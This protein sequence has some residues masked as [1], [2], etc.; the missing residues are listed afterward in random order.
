MYLM[1]RAGVRTV[2]VNF[3][4]LV[5]AAAVTLA[6]V[7]TGALAAEDAGDG[8]L[9][10]FQDVLANPQDNA[11]SFRYARQQVAEGNLTGAAASLERMLINNPDLHEVRLFHAVLLYRLDNYLEAEVELRRIPLAS[12][13]EK[14]RSE[15]ERYLGLIGK[16]KQTTRYFGIL[17][18]GFEYD[19][20]V[21]SISDTGDVLFLGLTLTIPDGPDDFG[22]LGRATVGFEHELQTE[23]EMHI[24]GDVTVFANEHIEAKSQSHQL[25]MGRVG[26]VF[27]TGAMDITPVAEGGVLRLS[28]EFFYS[29][30]GI[31]LGA[32]RRVAS[33]LSV[34]AGLRW[35]YEEFDAIIESPGADG[36]TGHRYEVGVGTTYRHAPSQILDVSFNF[37][38][39]DGK[40]DFEDYY[41]FRLNASLTVGLFEGHFA[42]LTITAGRRDYDGPEAF[43]SPGL[44]RTDQYGRA[45]LT[46]GLPL[47]YLIGAL[48]GGAPD[49]LAGIN[50][51]P[52]VE[53]Y[54]QSSNLPNFDYDNIKVSL[55]L[56]K[57]FDF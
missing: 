2:L 57:K 6:T 47:S 19:E 28:E 39:K 37:I 12:L 42:Q 32:T 51:L 40:V 43:V 27:R 50:V 35:R 3:K 29:F 54:K 1:G 38:G 10:S 15:V 46:Y 14:L 52:A 24:F 33:K 21:N 11:L 9:V 20:N 5:M 8:G 44:A 48:G 31:S 34:N 53:Y 22:F 17:G 41:G 36:R 26:T 16:R 45:R 49:Y 56:S 13:T 4:I 30:G 23:E 18:V 7:G 25:F 55:M